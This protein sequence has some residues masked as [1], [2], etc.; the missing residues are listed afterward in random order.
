MQSSWRALKFT[1]VCLPAGIPRR[2]GL[3]RWR[4]LGVLPQ[5]GTSGD[6]LWIQ[7][8]WWKLSPATAEAQPFRAESSHGLHLLT[9]LG[10]EAQSRLVPN[11]NTRTRKERALRPL[12]LPSERLEAI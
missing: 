8:R 10:G 6:D 9:N 12:L 2:T 7:A 1:G 3:A 5:P 11:Q 4:A